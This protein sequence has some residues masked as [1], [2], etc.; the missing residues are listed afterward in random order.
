[1]TTT[2]SKYRKPTTLDHLR[3]LRMRSCGDALDLFRPQAHQE[4]FFRSMATEI[5]LGGG[6][7]GGKTLCAA[8][9]FAAYCLNKSITFRDG[10]KICPRRA[11][12]N[13][14][15]LTFWIVC[16]DWNYV[17]STIYRSLFEPGMFKIIMDK[18][19]MEWVAYDPTNPDHKSREN[20]CRP[21][22]PLIPRHRMKPQDEWSWENRKDLQFRRADSVDD[23]FSIFIYPSSQKE[24]KAGDPVDAIWIDENLQYDKHYAEYTARLSDYR[25]RLLWSSW[26]KMGSPAL[27]RVRDKA[28]EQLSLPKEQRVVERFTFEFN[29]NAFI[30]QESKTDR[31]ASWTESERRQ[32]DLGEFIDDDYLMYF[33][34]NKRTHNAVPEHEELDNA[35]SRAIRQNNGAIPPNWR[36]DLILDPGTAHPAILLVA[37]PPPSLGEC[38]IAYDEIYPGRA[39]AEDLARIINDRHRGE[40]FQTFIIDSHAARQTPLGFGSTVGDNYTKVFSQYQVKCVETGSHFLPGSDNVEARCQMLIDA[41]L[42]RPDGTPKFRVMVNR[43]PNLVKQFEECMRAVDSDNNALNVP[44]KGQ[45]LD[46]LVCAEYFISRRVRYVPP[47]RDAYDPDDLVAAFERRAQYFNRLRQNSGSGAYSPVASFGPPARN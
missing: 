14:R 42:I 1:M 38:Y 34:F 33:G 22:P 37:T 41:L 16:Y 15:K 20:E 4:E 13:N 8:I 30:P 32:R 29:K 36:R 12:Q 25:G 47:K 39:T 6:N 3:E 44:A 17:G 9:W 28:N 24:A 5:L 7:R 43:C 10:T 27:I 21:S 2:D 45:K 11:H 19:T 26:A 31:A 23:T 40:V 46:V 18:E 35:V